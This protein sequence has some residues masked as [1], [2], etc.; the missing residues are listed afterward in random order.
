MLFVV[1]RLDEFRVGDDGADGLG[2]P[3]AGDG[4]L[5]TFEVH[6]LTGP[7]GEDAAF[8]EVVCDLLEGVAVLVEG[9][10]FPKDFLLARIGK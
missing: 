2:F 6:G 8:V 7:L 9:D 1:G 5:A 3:L 10:D 4:D